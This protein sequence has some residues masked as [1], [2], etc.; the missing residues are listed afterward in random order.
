MQPTY[1]STTLKVIPETPVF[2]HS[3][4]FTATFL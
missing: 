4:K 1:H 2:P 3:M